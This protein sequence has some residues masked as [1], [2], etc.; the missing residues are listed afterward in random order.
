MKTLFEYALL[1][2]SNRIDSIVEMGKRLDLAGLIS[3]AFNKPEELKKADAAY[4]AQAGMLPSK[5]DVMKRV[6]DMVAR[7]KKAGHVP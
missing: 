6:K 4:R 7:L 5:G 2:D 3:Y 1:L